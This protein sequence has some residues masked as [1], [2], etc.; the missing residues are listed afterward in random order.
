MKTLLMIAVLS[1]S[2]AN[3]QTAKVVELPKHEAEQAKQL[4]EAK[5]AAD[6]AWDD[7]N[8]KLKT[9]HTSFWDIEFSDDFRFIVP[10]PSTLPNWSIGGTT[11]I[12]PYVSNPAQLYM[13]PTGDMTMQIQR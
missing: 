12:C 6:K 4:Y 10:K 8:V 5:V 11:T 13:N 2:L 7:F 1:C 9:T 3:A